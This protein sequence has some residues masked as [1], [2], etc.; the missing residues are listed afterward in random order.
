M[1]QGLCWKVYSY[2]AKFPTFMEIGGS[3]PCSQK[4]IT[5]PYPEVV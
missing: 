4:P 3:L 1:V 2:S 5:E